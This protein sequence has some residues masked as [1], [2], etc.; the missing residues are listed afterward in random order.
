M[1][2]PIEISDKAW[3]N[4][5]QYLDSMVAIQSLEGSPDSDQDRVLAHI[6]SVV[7]P[8]IRE[9]ATTQK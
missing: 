8:A 2:T 5:L 7:I 9:L 1:L 3:Q 6:R 4:T